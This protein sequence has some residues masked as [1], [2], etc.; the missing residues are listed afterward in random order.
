MKDTKK[1][2][3]CSQSIFVKNLQNNYNS[4]LFN[5]YTWSIIFA[6]DNFAKEEISII[7]WKQLFKLIINIINNNF[8]III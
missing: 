7:F 6:S 1:M 5:L 3:I 2:S 8:T 4:F